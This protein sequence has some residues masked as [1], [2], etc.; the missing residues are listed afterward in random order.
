MKEM[1]ENLWRWRSE[2][3]EKGKKGNTRKE[4][5]R[6]ELEGKL[7]TLEEILEKTR[8]EERERKARIEEKKRKAQELRSKKEKAED[9]KKA[10]REK[11]LKLEESWA[12]IRWLT[13]YMDENKDTWKKEREDRQ[14]E[15]KRYQISLPPH[16]SHLQ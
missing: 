2:E 6:E 9:E 5:S 12:M 13:R 16:G 11:K 8:T 4:I 1:K 14:E 15:E 10:R 3:E 7:E